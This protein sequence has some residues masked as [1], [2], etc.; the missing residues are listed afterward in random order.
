MMAAL[1]A[2]FFPSLTPPAAVGVTAD[3]G[4]PETAD[5]ATPVVMAPEYAAARPPLLAPTAPVI[6]G[7]GVV[8]P[9]G[10]ALLPIAVVATCATPTAS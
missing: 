2:F 3:S 4:G 7:A 8:T 6:E 9:A 1:S 5:A 10:P